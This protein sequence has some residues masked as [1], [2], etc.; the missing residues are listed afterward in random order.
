MNSKRIISLT[1]IALLAAGLAVAG[2]GESKEKASS[3]KPT[4]TVSASQA[5]VRVNAPSQKMTA[6]YM[7]IQASQ[8]DSLISASVSDQV[9]AE[10]TLHKTVTEGGMTEMKPV[11][12]IPVGKGVTQLKPGGYHVML[13]GL[14]RPI[15]AGEEVKI[16]LNFQKGG[17]VQA[18][19]MGKQSAMQG[20][21]GHTDKMN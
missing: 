12:A 3:A 6:A 18:E 7:V 9:A 11:D 13:E 21:S 15:K 17:Q 14:K 5:W 8:A 1:P 2:C 19:A 4:V 20:M 16:T 10:T